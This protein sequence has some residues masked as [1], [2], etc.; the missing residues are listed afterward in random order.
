MDA[1]QEINEADAKLIV[2]SEKTESV[3]KGFFGKLRRKLGL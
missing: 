3:L 2:K 1:V